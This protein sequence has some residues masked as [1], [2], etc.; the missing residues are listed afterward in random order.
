MYTRDEFRKNVF[1]FNDASLEPLKGAFSDSNILLP[2][3]GKRS[4]GKHRR[5]IFVE[6]KCRGNSQGWSSS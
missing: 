5:P 2:S 4:A 6:I 1:V 3:V